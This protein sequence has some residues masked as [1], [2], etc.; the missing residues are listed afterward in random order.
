MSTALLVAVL[1]GVISVLGWFVSH[2][3]G[4]RADRRRARLAAQISHVEKQLSELYGPLA[5]FIYEGR[6]TSE[7]LLQTLG[8]RHVFSVDKPLPDDELRTWLFWVDQDSFN[9]R[10]RPSGLLSRLP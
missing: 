9:P 2:L 4:S 1:A 5:F 10:G 8:R 3:L 7:D 6:A